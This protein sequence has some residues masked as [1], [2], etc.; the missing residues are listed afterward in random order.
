MWWWTNRRSPAR[1]PSPAACSEQ[2]PG[3]IR[4]PVGLAVAA[5]EQEDQGFLRQVLHGVLAAVANTGSGL[6]LSW[7][8][9][10]PGDAAGRRHDPAA[11]VAERRDRRRSAP[12]LVVRW[13][14]TTRSDARVNCVPASASSA[15]AAGTRRAFR[16]RY[17]ASFEIC[18]HRNM[19]GI[20]YE[21]VSNTRLQRSCLVK[22]AHYAE[23]AIA[24]CGK[25]RNVSGCST[26]RRPAA[27]RA[28]VADMTMRSRRETVHFK[29]PF[30]ITGHRSPAVAG[31]L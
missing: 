18:P 26:H 8:R 13:S 2:L 1:A 28:P 24:N 7:C 21:A 3:D 17:A 14:G 5:A 30:R 29:H 19:G 25:A 11:P 15:S 20:G 31:R 27:R 9:R 16:I 23:K 6:P 12:G 4:K 22:C 10:R